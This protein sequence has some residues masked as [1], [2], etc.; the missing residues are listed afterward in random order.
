MMLHVFVKKS[1]KTPT[2]ELKIAR[3]TMKEVQAD[4]DA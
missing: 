1:V 4:A 3:D 2:K